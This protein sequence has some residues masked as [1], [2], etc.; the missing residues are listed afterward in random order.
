M[1]KNLIRITL[2]I[3]LNLFAFL[4]FAIILGELF[5]NKKQFLILCIILSIIPL[6]I[7]LYI[8]IQKTLKKLNNISKKNKNGSNWK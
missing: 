3:L 7:F 8:E 4:F 6:L 1:Y 5:W 2:V